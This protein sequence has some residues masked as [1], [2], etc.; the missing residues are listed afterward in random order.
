MIARSLASAFRN[1]LK[2]WRHW[3]PNPVLLKELR[4][5]M[6][7]RVLTGMLLLLLAM[8]FMGAVVFM[9]GRSFLADDSQQLGQPVCRIFLV[10]LTL[11]TLLF[12]PL[13]IGVRLAVERIQSNLDLMFVTTLTPGRIVRGKWM[14]G[15]YLTAM[16]FSVCMPF[17]VFT[18]FL[19]GVDVPTVLFGLICLYCVVCLAIQAA[20]FFACLPVHGAL[21]SLVGLVFVLGLLGLN[22]G[23]IAFF[24]GLL[25]DG[26]GAMMKSLSAWVGCAGLGLLMLG[27]I[28]ALHSMSVTMIVTDSRPRGYFNEIIREEAL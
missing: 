22:W 28:R 15:A 18:N 7:S 19:R 20:I 4:Q 27:A 16:F 23:L 24:F 10:I 25:Q 1:R 21:K 8:L 12:V 6:R 14:C 2:S 11:S 26:V 3:E 9:A 5:A 17:M 13:Y